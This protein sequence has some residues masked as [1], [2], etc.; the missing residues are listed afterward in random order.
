MKRTR[1]SILIVLAVVL[2]QIAGCSA[3]RKNRHAQALSVMTTTNNVLASNH[4]AGV[5]S[6]E[7]LLDLKPYIRAGNAAVTQAGQFVNTPEATEFDIW[8]AA[9][10]QALFHLTPHTTGVN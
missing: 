8:M 4:E 10:E 7:T 6:D 5:I 3:S 1:L 2:S 9:F